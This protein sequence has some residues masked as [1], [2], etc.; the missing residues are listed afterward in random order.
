MAQ[1]DHQRRHRPGTAAYT[2]GQA[3]A[4]SILDVARQIVIND[5][6]SQLTMRRIARELNM[7][8]GNLSYYYASKTDLLN[9]LC[10]AMLAPYLE[11]FERLRRLDAD[12]PMD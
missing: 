9:D 6:M 7:S 8:P 10:S 3:T 4:A 1:T 11:E 12:S 5:G 2:K